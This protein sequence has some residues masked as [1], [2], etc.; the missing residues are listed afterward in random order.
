M[1]TSR[2]LNGENMGNKIPIFLFFL[3]FIIGCTTYDYEVCNGNDCKRYVGYAVQPSVQTEKICNP[4]WVRDQAISEC[5][6]IPTNQLLS[7]TGTNKAICNGYSINGNDFVDN[8]WN[9]E[10]LIDECEMPINSNMQFIFKQHDQTIRSHTGTMQIK[11]DAVNFDRDYKALQVFIAEDSDNNNL[12]DSWMYCGNVDDIQGY[13]T[14][15]IRCSGAELKFI[16][17]VNAGWNKGSLFI[18]NFE[19]LKV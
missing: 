5:E 14:K 6:E 9:A 8:W 17:L 3:L 19:V 4:D 10:G 11:I 18:D 15:I 2:K 13:S 1:L 7:K 12:P 16:K